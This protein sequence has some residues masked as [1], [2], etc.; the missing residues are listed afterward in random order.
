VL[1]ALVTLRIVG[2][3]VGVISSVAGC[4]FESAALPAGPDAPAVV[5]VVDAPTMVDGIVDSPMAT[6]D[7]ADET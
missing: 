6:P 2:M 7:A 5:A 1:R 3:A 4:N